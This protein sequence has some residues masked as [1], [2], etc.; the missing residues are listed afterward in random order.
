MAGEYQTLLPKL[1][2]HVCVILIGVV[3]DVVSVDALWGGG[4]RDT[5]ANDT[6]GRQR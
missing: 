5:I 1:Q 2:V 6:T 4:S 3:D